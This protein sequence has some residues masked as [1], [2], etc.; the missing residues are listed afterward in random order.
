MS[1]NK[2]HCLVAIHQPNFFP[3]LGYFDKIGRADK[4]IFFD[5]VQFPKKG[6]IW[7]NRVKLLIG[8]EA[9]W[10]TAA[11]DRNYTGT[12]QICE[13]HFLSENPWRQKM[14]KSLEANYKRHLFYTETMALIEPLVLNEESNIAEHNIHAVTEIAK[15]MGID[16]GKMTRSSEYK[17]SSSSNELLCE[18]TLRIGGDVYMC[19]GGADGYQDE[20]VFERHGMKL[21]YQNFSHPVYTQRGQAEFVP[22]LSVIDAAM[23]LGWDSVR[24]LLE[25][26]G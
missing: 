17:T 4:F 20:S 9:R 25:A 26:H 19:G 22:G 21:L 6:G 16:T 24:K 8:G 11:I 2:N 12:R 5:S 7:S 14:L 23:N 1:G 3:W 15:Q 13:M 10:V 18:L